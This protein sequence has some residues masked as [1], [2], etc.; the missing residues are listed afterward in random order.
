LLFKTPVDMQKIFFEICR[1]FGHTPSKRFAS[2]GLENLETPA[3]RS[4]KGLSRSVQGLLYFLIT[5]NKLLLNKLLEHIN[6][7]RVLVRKPLRKRVCGI[8]GLR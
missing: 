4:P 7:H 3:S 6:A 5:H 8:H 1:K 2:P